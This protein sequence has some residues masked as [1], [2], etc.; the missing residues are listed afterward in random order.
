MKPSG[1]LFTHVGPKLKLNPSKPSQLVQ[2][3]GPVLHAAQG[4]SHLKQ[5]PA[6]APKFGGHSFT[7][8]FSK[9]SGSLEFI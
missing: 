5:T 7:Q 9:S 6:T 8:R 2:M 1:H 3:L 4:E